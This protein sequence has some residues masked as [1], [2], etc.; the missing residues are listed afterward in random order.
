[1]TIH[2]YH[3]EYAMDLSQFLIKNGYSESDIELLR[4]KQKE[5][6]ERNIPQP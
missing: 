3:K 4:L 5:E 6:D 1:M 2:L